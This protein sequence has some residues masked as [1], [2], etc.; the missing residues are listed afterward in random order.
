MS[1][2]LGRSL[3]I[4]L[5]N[6]EVKVADFTEELVRKFLGGRGLNAWQLLEHVGPETDPLGPENILILSCGLLTG[7][8]APAS[9]RLHVSALSPLT[10]L[11]GSSNVGGHFGAELRA[12]GFQSLLIRGRAERP[13]ALWLHDGGVEIRDA[14]D[15]WG[16]DAW[17]TQNHL[18]EELGQARAKIM[19]IGPGGENGVRYACIMTERGHAAGRTD[20]GAV[21]GSNNLEAIAV[22]KTSEVSQDFRRL[23]DETI[24]ALVKQYIQQIRN[25]PRYDTYARYS[26][27]AYV[28]WAREEGLLSTR[29]YRQTQ[30]EGA[31]QIDGRQIIKYVTRSRSCYRCPVHCKAD[32][33]VPSGRFATEGDRP[34]I[35][36]IVAL[37]SKCGLD[38]VEAL[39]YLYNL[40]GQL[41]IDVISTGGVLAFA[42]ELYERGIL[43]E[44]DTG[45]VALA[46]GNAEAMETV[47]R[48]IAR[49]EGLGDVL[50]EGV[51]RA[52]QLIGRGA[53]QYAFH[54]KGL[55]MT[56][57]DPRGALGTALGYAVSTRGADFTSVYAIP[58]YRWDAAQG[59]EVFGTEKAVDRLSIEGKGA[60]IKRS[61][62]VS[63]ILD[64]LGLCKVPILSVV[65]D[66]SLEN[67]AALASAL[68]G[69][70]LTAADLLIIGERILN[71]ER[72]FNLRHGATPADD[73]LPD[74]FTEEPLPDGPTQGMTVPIQPM[75]RDFYAVMSWDAEGQPTPEKLRELGLE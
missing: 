3:I 5:T 33:E 7:T 34:D 46:W 74:R 38:D 26:N 40:A 27:S 37:G 41:G 55:E 9:S 45:G 32:V 14:D 62:I 39:L 53:E 15:L 73:D 50:A 13:V 44:E 64:S 31:D 48:Q 17:V 22:C 6:R 61:M 20:M 10:G 28:T 18:R 4:N 19:A 30:F 75:V 57:Y 67:E 29:N 12:A 47:M 54:S 23:K 56:A 25:S 36:P 68:S 58:E 71:V 60:L 8:Q 65:G 72:L 24:R 66:F 21:I 1:N 70:P 49:R 51:K 16:Q 59:R 2:F 42:M 11:L 52:A 63:A 35:E 43:T 69:W